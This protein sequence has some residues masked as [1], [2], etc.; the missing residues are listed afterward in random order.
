M[1]GERREGVLSMVDKT[2]V[3]AIM[4]MSINGAFSAQFMMAIV[5]GREVR[6]V[7]DSFVMF[8]SYS[9]LKLQRG[10]C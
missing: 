5:S 1:G 10:V 9:V 2:S 8:T 3:L 4:A 7:S 6:P